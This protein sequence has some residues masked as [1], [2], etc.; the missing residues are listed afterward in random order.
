MSTKS[1][2]TKSGAAAQSATDVLEM[3]IGPVPGSNLYGQKVN[4][5]LNLEEII[6]ETKDSDR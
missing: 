4:P 2:D 5:V 6:S 1:W 3:D